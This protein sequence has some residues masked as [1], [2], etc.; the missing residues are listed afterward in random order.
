[1]QISIQIL[2]LT[3]LAEHLSSIVLYLLQT[4][5]QISFQHF[6]IRSFEL[7][8]QM[9]KSSEL[10]CLYNTQRALMRIEHSCVTIFKLTILD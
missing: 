7:Q 8:I 10:V 4:F 5:R 6:I 3:D 9:S 2:Q 1:M